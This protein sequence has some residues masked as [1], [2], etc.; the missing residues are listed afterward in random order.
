MSTTESPPEH[1]IKQATPIV[2]LS[3]PFDMVTTSQTLALVEQMIASRRP[4]YLIMADVD[5]AVRAMRDVEVRRI[6]LE[7]HLILSDGMPLVWASRWLGNP[8]PERIAA[9]DLVP[10]LLRA[11]EEKGWRVFFLGAKDETLVRA[12]EKLHAQ[13]PR[14]QIAGHLSP[15]A[16]PLQEMDHAGICRAI[17]DAKP[18]ILL[19]AFGS[20]A[21][22]KWVNTRYRAAGVPV[23][24]GVGDAMDFVAGVSPRAPMWM[25]QAGLEWLFRVIREPQRLFRRYL[26]DLWVFGWGI[27]GQW[28]RLQVRRRRV[29]KYRRLMVV[30]EKTESGFEMVRIPPRFDAAVVR[31]N[32][33][34]WKCFATAP[35]H[36][37]FDMTH[38]QFID[39]TGIGLLIRL[40]KTLTASNCRFVLVSPSTIAQQ[41]LERVRVPDLLAIVPSLAAAKD[42]I[43]GRPGGVQAA[44]TLDLSSTPKPLMWHGEIVASNVQAVQHLSESYLESCAS[45][46]KPCVIDLAGVSFVSSAGVGLMGRLK[47]LG[48][49]RGV[50]VAFINPQPNVLKVIQTFRLDKLLFGENV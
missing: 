46:M 23:S 11:A 14:L 24:I 6:L 36:L 17:R 39:S 20:P 42:I 10:T 21:Q 5:F 41:S 18:D 22:E 25:Q 12:K 40:H 47:K 48:R 13:H 50:E 31:E 44:A 26:L 43:A 4:H 45:E 30:A 3:V 27:L 28:W 38:V 7:A 9:P 1:K 35:V 49:L 32:E 16:V 15:P 2:I 29:A 8:L 19:V 37:L 33:W 34:L